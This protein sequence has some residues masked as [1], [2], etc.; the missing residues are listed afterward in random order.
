M[1]AVVVERC[2]DPEVLKIREVRTPV[3]APGQILVRLKAAGV[4]PVDTY[5]RSGAQG[6]APELPWTPGLDGTGIVEASGEGVSGFEKGMR[7]YLCGSISGTYAEYCLCTP[8]QAFALPETLDWVEGACLGIPYFTAARA[9]FTKGGASSGETVLI[10]GA[11]GGVGLAALQ[12]ASGKGLRLLGTA[13]SSAGEKMVRANGAECYSHLDKGRFPAIREAYGGVDLIVEM[14]ADANLDEDLKLLSPGGRVVV[15]GS[16]GRVEISPRDL[17]GSEGTVTGMRVLNATGAERRDYA[18]L[19]S[20]GIAEGTVKPQV[21]AVFSLEEADRAHRE[22][23]G[24]PHAGNLV[25]GI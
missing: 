6:Y 22:V 10:H 3:P 14:L 15:V 20:R 18:A 17:M 24:G 11:S 4:N 2:G 8:E 7:V 9:L 1:K 16:R 19:V 23:I 13:G 5:I 12:L 25:I 21:S